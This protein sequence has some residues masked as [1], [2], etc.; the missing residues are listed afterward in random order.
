[1]W[2]FQGFR[3]RFPYRSPRA[4][5]PVENTAYCGQFSPCFQGVSGLS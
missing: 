4:A 2:K 1:M 3:P 5:G